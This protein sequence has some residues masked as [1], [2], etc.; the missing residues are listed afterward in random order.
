M[1]G[2]FSIMSHKVGCRSFYQSANYKTFDSNRDFI[3]SSSLLL[4]T[5]ISSQ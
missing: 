1:D 3:S 4:I 2:E 5:A